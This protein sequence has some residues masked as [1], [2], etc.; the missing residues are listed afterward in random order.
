[1][2]VAASA[3]AAINPA[4]EVVSVEGKGEYR[5]AQQTTWR[6]VSLR[7]PLFPT[8]YVRTLD[9]SRMAILFSDRTQV[10]LAQ[11]SMLQIKEVASG[12][13]TKTILNLNSGRAWTQSKTTPKGLVME[14][15]SALA[16]IRGT[17][18]EMAVDDEG[19]ATLSVFSGEVEFYNDQGNIV[20]RENEQAR[21]E[22]GKAPVKLQLQVSRER[23]QWVSA[24][25]IDTQRYA[26]L[27]KGATGELAQI[28]ALVR[29]QRLSEAY[30]R[31]KH[32]VAGAG[33]PAVAYL[34]LADFEIYRGET[35]A[36]H[37]VLKRGGARFPADERFDV[38]LARTAL[39][40]DDAAGALA[41]AKSA[42]AKRPDSPDALVMLGDI[43]RHDGRAKEAIAAYSRAAA[44]AAGE[45][46]AWYGL[47]VVESERE[48]FRRARSHL[49]KAIALDE[50]EPTYRAELGTLEG[51]AGNFARGRNELEKALAMQPDNYVALTGLG[52]LELKSGHEDAALDALLRASLIEPRYARAHLYLAV[53]YY[54]IGRD[55][56]AI[57]E[58]HRAAELDTNDPLPHLLMSIIHLD[59][60]EPG[61]A[62][63][64]AQQALSRIPYLKSLNQ[65]ADNQ[66]GVANVGAPLAFMGLEA[67]ARSAA[68][69]SYLPFWGGSHLFLA[70]RYPGEFDRRS[71][72]MQGFITD[73]LV[74]GASNRFQSLLAEPGHHGT[75]SLRYAQS[76]EL[77]V[78]EPT[79]T[80]TGYDVSR[81]P[82]AYF[83]EAIDTRIDPRDADTT[84]RAKTFTGA[85]GAK[86]TH[87]LGV[88]LFANRLSV[89]AQFGAPDAAGGFA[90]IDGATTRVDGGLRYAFDA[91]SSLWI[92]AGAG[93]ND[94]TLDEVAS[95]TFDNQPLLSQSHFVTRPRS[96]DLA[97]RYTVVPRD[98]V[99]I[100]VGAETS[101]LREPKFLI[102]DTFLHSAN[103]TSPQESLDEVDRDRAE[104]AYAAARWG[105]AALRL[106][107]GAAWSFYRK[108][109]DIHVVREGV[110]AVDIRLFEKYRRNRADPLVGVTWRI[111][112]ATLGRAACRRWMR[113]IAGDTLAPVA[114][115]GM[116]L[117]DQLVFAGGVI[118]QCRGQL[119]W[120]AFDRTFVTAL[121]ERS[122]VHNLLSVLDG[123]L[124]TGSETTNLD[125]LRNRAL[126][127]PPK[128]DLLEA[129]PV[130]GE[131][132]ARRA[133]LAVEQIVTPRIGMRAHYTYT[134]SENTDP[135]LPGKWIPYL[136]RHQANF[137]LTWAPGWRSYL[138][139][140]AVYRSRRYADEPNSVA[141]PAGWDAQVN[142][143]VESHDKRWAVEA[144]A[145][146]LFKKETS[147]VF[148]I[149][150]SYR[151]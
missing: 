80:L 147:D 74:F 77:R 62:V 7:H 145:A 146:N 64:E 25:T 85:F 95:V 34:L 39:L 66:K 37:D 126:T 124:N 97:L 16:A 107:I 78:V 106:D 32:D 56:A 11:N 113:P 19:R 9:M 26:E 133:T 84:I 68:H 82:V 135:G 123:V 125:R 48:N 127:P 1:M 22:R 122:R 99:E 96:S 36:T 75:A 138:T 3:S 51:Y 90:R 67:W 139:A 149:V 105:D 14:T 148:G 35:G 128:P 130:Y 117:D 55:E 121:V 44:I 129:V 102:R 58:L 21:A 12:P 94:A 132:I 103:A 137:G 70:D 10:R 73:P 30:E 33:A 119:E 27:R 24:F 76:D 71:E 141:L 40:G 93:R 2:G 50:S 81:I 63:K 116:P 112:P 83:V 98:R 108:D 31:L 72:L 57:A 120:T 59:R 136:A 42:L 111:A 91:N 46:R 115:A 118:E 143:F 18:W 17:D 8:N 13:D 151:F 61:L 6:P 38:G 53:A 28:A 140:Q 45:G 131:G 69:E 110:S 92:K 144:F 150:L 134:E 15:P 87:E 60:I 86:P 142:L 104:S 47:G 23:I 20:V 101:R 54:R 49:E 100:S 41:H 43:Q 65:V 89:D 114:V 79:L 52:V 109:R 88:F 29:E 5:E 4:A